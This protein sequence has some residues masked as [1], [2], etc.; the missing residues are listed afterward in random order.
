M[1]EL[2]QPRNNNDSKNQFKTNFVKSIKMNSGQI[3]QDFAQALPAHEAL[4]YLISTGD[5]AGAGN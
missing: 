1:G 4:L 3:I 5:S 2:Q